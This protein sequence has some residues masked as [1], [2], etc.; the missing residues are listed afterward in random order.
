[1]PV[2]SQNFSVRFGESVD[3]GLE[4]QKAFPFVYS[5]VNSD[6]DTWEQDKGT[7]AGNLSGLALLVPANDHRSVPIRLDPD[8]TFKL[9][10]TKYSTYV[11]DRGVYTWYNAPVAGW[12]LEQPNP[13]MN[14][15]TPWTNSIA[16]SLS[17]PSN[18]GVYV[19]GGANTDPVR[20][21]N[22]STM[23]LALVAMQGADF[24]FGQ[25]RTPYLLPRAGTVIVEITNVHP[26]QDIYVAGI[27]YGM[28]VRV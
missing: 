16:V 5:F 1:M 13:E 25:L 9:L 17:V 26:T 24:G 27:L 8:C 11:I 18:Q 14:A 15:A 28:K 21:P 3:K 2:N 10:W 23:P 22:R 6:D 4:K 7:P 19:Y 12:F 20:N